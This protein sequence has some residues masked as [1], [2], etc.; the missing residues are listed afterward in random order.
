MG[1]IGQWVSGLAYLFFFHDV[2]W[3]VTFIPLPYMLGVE[4][5]EFRALGVELLE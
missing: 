2:G 3:W 1:L 5:R 4:L